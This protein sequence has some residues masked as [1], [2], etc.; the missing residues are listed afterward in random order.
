MASSTR[1]PPIPRPRS[2]THSCRCTPPASPRP[3]CSGRSRPIQ[4][5][6]S[7]AADPGPRGGGHR[8]RARLRRSRCV[9]GRRGLW[10]HRRL[11]RRLGRRRRGHR[12]AQPGTETTDP[13][14][15]PGRRRPA[16]HAHVVAGAV[17]PRPSGARP[18]GGHPRGRRWRRIDGGAPGPLGRC[19]RDRNR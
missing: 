15:R 3:S 16:G 13:R 7:R 4:P 12:G 9:R 5:T 10:P 11:P 19:P 1:T 6:R 17:R 8:R 2:A 18:D 14:L